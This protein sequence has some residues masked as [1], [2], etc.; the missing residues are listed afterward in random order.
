MANGPN[1]SSFC[2]PFYN[3]VPRLSPRSLLIAAVT[4]AVESIGS[5]CASQESAPPM[6]MCC[7]ATRAHPV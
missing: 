1:A 3:P 7:P 6:L 5:A 4:L 2:A